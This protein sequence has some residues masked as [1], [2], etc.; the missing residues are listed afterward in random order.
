LFAGAVDGA[1]ASATEASFLC[2][3]FVTL[4]LKIDDSS[5]HIVEA[6]YRTNGCGY[7]L[8]ACEVMAATLQ[9]KCLTDLKGNSREATVVSIIEQLQDVPNARVHCVG[10]AADVVRTAL[11]AYR[12]KQ[13]AE[14]RGDDALICTCFG[15]SE[16]SIEKCI[17]ENQVTR[18]EQVIDLCRAGGGCGSCQP[19]VQQLIDD[20]RALTAFRGKL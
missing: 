12:A 2:G 20:V 19:L 1:N 16:R 7:L 4:S 11:A 15:I 5:A 8:A 17:V 13:V 6:R 9:G 10:L 18:V 14:Y 3:A